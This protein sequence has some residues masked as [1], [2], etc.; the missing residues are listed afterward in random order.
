MKAIFQDIFHLLGSSEI[1]LD[2]TE[3]SATLGT[4]LQKIRDNLINSKPNG[5]FLNEALCQLQWFRIYIWL[6]S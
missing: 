1:L 6:Q 4:V 5:F 3:G 2:D